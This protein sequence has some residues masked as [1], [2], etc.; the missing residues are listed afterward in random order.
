MLQIAIY[1]HFCT[2]KYLP[3]VVLRHLIQD[4][5]HHKAQSKQT[6][7]SCEKSFNI[8]HKRV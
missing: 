2:E 4:V 8:F 6:S 7:S 3:M 5:F 1:R